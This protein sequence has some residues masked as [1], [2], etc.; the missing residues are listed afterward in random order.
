ME[1]KLYGNEVPVHV[2]AEW[3]KDRQVADHINEPGHRERLLETL[4]LAQEFRPMNADG[5]SDWG[6]GN[7]GLLH[8]LK[9][10]IPLLRSWGYDLMPSNVDYAKTI[11]EVDV[12]LMDIVKG[13]PIAG[14]SVI[15]TEILEHLVHP[16]RLLRS[17][18]HQRLRKF[19]E[20]VIASSPAF[21]TP[22]H[23][24]EF[25]L[26]AWTNES[27]RL[28]FERAG[29]RVLRHFVTACNGTQFIVATPAE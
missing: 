1:F 8:E 6:A 28:M 12:Q 17:L 19:A 3:H 22:E 21:E 24:Y 18:V 26:W 27:Y 16:H 4:A 9:E 14:G 7:G 20:F 13:E 25:H 5:L 23:H 15:L 29:Y 10:K 11:Y 2:G